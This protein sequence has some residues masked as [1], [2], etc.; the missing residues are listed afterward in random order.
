MNY[1]Q[2]L[3]YLFNKFPMYYRIG[4]AAYKA[5]LVNTIQLCKLLNN[6][7][8][9]FKSIHIAGTNGKGSVSH[10]LASVLQTKGFKVGLYTSPHLK[11]FRER[12]KINGKLIPKGYTASFISKYKKEFDKTG[13]SFF[14]MTVGLAFRYFADEKV[15]IAVIETGL[16]GRLDSTNIINPLLSIITNISFDHT[17][18]LGDSLQKIAFEKA[19][20]IKPTTPV[21]IG[22]TQ[23][24]ISAVFIDKANELRAPIYFA[25]SNYEVRSSELGVRKEDL[26]IDIY[27]KDKVF[28]NS[29]S[30]PLKGIY[31]KKNVITVIQTIEILNKTGYNISKDDIKKGVN[32]V[33]KSTGLIGRWQILS[34]SP[35]TI[36]DVGHNEAGIKM[37]VEQIKNTPHNKLHFVFGMVNDKDAD[38]ILKL[39]PKD[40][41][42]YFCK[43]DIPRGLDEDILSEKAKQ[44]GLKGQAYPS[45][46]D[47]FLCAKQNADKDDL[48]FIG[49]SVFVV[50]EVL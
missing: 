9:S 15:D 46:K 14:E 31:Q 48:V 5:D 21:V 42:Y 28:I 45:V 35:L 29:L 2:T 38:K 4:P 11:D 7:Q 49:G 12:I 44:A 19:G 23:N 32:D 39:L 27:S 47:A 43:A 16:G 17:Q 8:N 40:A 26:L 36:C 10:M 13:L 18:F 37:V 33:V 3:E 22:E 34:K 41:I 1:S 25:D 50:A 24:E 6:P 20:I 30:L